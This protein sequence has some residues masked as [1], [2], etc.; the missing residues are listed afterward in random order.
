MTTSSGRALAAVRPFLPILV[1]ALLA[2]IAFTD[3][4]LGFSFLSGPETVLSIVAALGLVVRRRLPYVSLAL[5]LPGL[6]VGSALIA[7]MI[8]LYS[9]A[10]GTRRRLPLV[11][12]TVITLAG[13]IVVS[14][15]PEDVQ[16]LTFSVIYGVLFVGGP[17][18]LGLL[19]RTRREL[20]TRIVELHAAQEEERRLAADQALA[21][22][23]ANLAREMHDVV[24]HQISLV[25]VQAGALQVQTTD[26]DVRGTARTIRQLC[27]TTLEELRVM[28]AVLRRAGTPGAP[29]TAPQPRLVDVP[30]LIEGSGIPSVV[31]LDLPEDLPANVQRTIY[32]T[33][34]E[35][36]TNAR[37]HAPGATVTIRAAMTSRELT[38]TVHSGPRMLGSAS[39]LP[40]AGVGLTGLS[41]RAALLGGTLDTSQ[42]PKGFTVTL[43]IPTSWSVL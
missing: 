17:I 19:A 11:L 3:A 23:R 16:E 25:A 20:A 15:V 26:P 10:S 4:L 37:K 35:G 24:S 6:F 41:E 1:D 2:G 31:D 21:T 29:E 43:T 34:Q 30:K 18:A 12:A 38:L 36:L 28:V 42:G 27:V 22:E 5:A 8:A 9:V 39:P 7:A 14:E 32:R 33:I 13:Y 40:G